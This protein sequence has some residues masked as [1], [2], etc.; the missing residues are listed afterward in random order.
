M[1]R[2]LLLSINSYTDSSFICTWNDGLH[3]P[4]G[5]TNCQI[6][7]GGEYIYIPHYIDARMIDHDPDPKI[8]DMFLIFRPTPSA[9]EQG[10]TRGAAEKGLVW[11]T[12]ARTATV[13]GRWEQIS[14]IWHWGGVRVFS[15]LSFGP[16]R[17]SGPW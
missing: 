8:R 17:N 5:N 13:V 7:W 10:A 15:L 11:S 6:E 9:L 14:I 12:W 3:A 16:C 4:S 2:L 1:L